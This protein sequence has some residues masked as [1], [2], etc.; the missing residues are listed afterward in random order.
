MTVCRNEIRPVITQKHVPRN[1]TFKLYLTRLNNTL[2]VSMLGVVLNENWHT[3]VALTRI[4]LLQTGRSW[5]R[6]GVDLFYKLPADRCDAWGFIA[7]PTSDPCSCRRVKYSAPGGSMVS[8]RAQ[9]QCLSITSLMLITG[10]SMRKR[11][12]RCLKV[13]EN[14]KE[15]PIPSN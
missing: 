14:S 13:S 2:S 11:L 15:F 9:P 12:Q 4:Y 10:A 7:R 6:R 8:L 3:R 1:M 5:S